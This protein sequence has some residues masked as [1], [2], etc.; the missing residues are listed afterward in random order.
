[1]RF[2]NIT[3]SVAALCASV[4]L[5]SASALAEQSGSLSTCAKLAG[6]VHEALASNMQSANYEA[7]TKEKGYG[8]D[9]CLNGLYGNGV[10]HY[11]QALRLL[12]AAK[13]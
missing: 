1:M 11:E 8:R 12:G 7:A 4:A 5:S 6:E 9:F 13:S 3:M 2:M 10:A